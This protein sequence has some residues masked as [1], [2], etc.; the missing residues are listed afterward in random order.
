MTTLLLGEVADER[1]LVA[2]P[3]EGLEQHNDPRHKK[4][5]HA[6]R[7]DEP[8]QDR[9]DGDNADREPANVQEDGLPGMEADQG[10]LVVG[11]N[12]EEDDGRDDSDL[13]VCRG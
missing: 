11:R 12:H 3:F 9:D 1:Q 2:F 10:L 7:E 5:E 8:T 6:N 4:D 13:G